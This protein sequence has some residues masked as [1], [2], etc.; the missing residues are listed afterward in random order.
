[1]KSK[2]AQMIKEL[3]LTWKLFEMIELRIQKKIGWVLLGLV[4]ALS[5]I[6][7]AGEAAEQLAADPRLHPGEVRILKI[8]DSDLQE[9][10]PETLYMKHWFG[11]DVS[12]AYFRFMEGKGTSKESM[13]AMHQHGEEW[14]IQL[15]GNSQVIE[16]DGTVH[17]IAQGDVFII[18]PRILHTGTFGNEENVILGVI[19]PPRE[20]YPA[21]G[22]KSYYP[23]QGE[24]EQ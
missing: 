14:A 19:T 17:E 20:D 2:L 8:D 12:V 4:N 21:E 22:I 11:T 18:T 7:L 5:P 16:E 24:D 1:M 6:A 13:P 10:I 3:P 9:I 15:K 23:G